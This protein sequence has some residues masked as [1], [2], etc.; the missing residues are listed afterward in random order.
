[1]PFMAKVCDISAALNMGDFVN[2]ENDFACWDN[3]GNY[4]SES[5]T[6]ISEICKENA[7]GRVSL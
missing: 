5:L 1:M 6:K 3:F 4:H 2:F 7:Y